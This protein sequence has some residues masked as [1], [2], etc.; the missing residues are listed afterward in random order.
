MP[1]IDLARLKTQAATLADNFSNYMAFISQLHDMLELYTNH[2]LRASQVV[3][4]FSLPTYNTP[5]PVLRQIEHELQP[6]AERLPGKGV[7]LVLELWKDGTYE[8]RLLAARLTGMIPPSEVM[9]IL[10]HFQD[11][12]AHSID[13]EVRKALLTDAFTRIRSENIEAF[14][15]LI[16]EWLKSP[17][18]S[19][20]SWGLQ[21]LIPVLN[22]A[23]FE[24][25]PV[26][27]RILQP[28]IR[29]AG[30]ATQVDLQACLR[31]LE[32]VSRTET[33]VYLRS[34][35]VDKPSPLLLR[36]IRRMLPSFS[37]HLQ[38]AIREVLREKETTGVNPS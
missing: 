19:H 5:P 1:A 29:S 24:N 20:Q 12:L 10:T 33:I 28:A 30:P 4:R 31:H 8:S 11:W 21:A 22:D 35:L 36:T 3:K 25:L 18:Y 15:Q 9:P 26:V 34:I 7:L 23:Y 17:Q 38:A 32:G 37:P 13:K 6:M 14:F 27:F 16:E 2:S